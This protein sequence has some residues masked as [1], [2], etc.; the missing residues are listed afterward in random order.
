MKVLAIAAEEVHGLVAWFGCT[1][2]D[3]INYLAEKW[4]LTSEEAGMIR[5]YCNPTVP[6][7]LELV[8][9]ERDSE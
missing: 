5:E 7:P 3:A 8:T 1:Y 2:D 6:K 9:P 4:L